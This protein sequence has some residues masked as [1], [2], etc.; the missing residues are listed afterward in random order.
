MPISAIDA[1]KYLSECGYPGLSYPDGVDETD[2]TLLNQLAQSHAHEVVH[3]R[4][5]ASRHMADAERHTIEARNIESD[6]YR[7]V[8]RIWSDD[9]HKVG[10]DFLDLNLDARHEC[11]HRVRGTVSSDATDGKSVPTDEIAAPTDGR[12]YTV[13]ITMDAHDGDVKT[14]SHTCQV[15]YDP[16]TV[17]D[18]SSGDVTNSY[19]KNLTVTRNGADA[20][21]VIKFRDTVL[22]W[23][24]EGYTLTS[25]TD[26]SL[27]FELRTM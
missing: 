25:I 22:Y 26:N 10:S 21:D 19:V 6:M 7:I 17:T 16:L 4:N 20:N 15:D 13:T 14:H 12:S 3:H 27:V 18:H 23:L 8:E 1:A 5:L 9:P 24:E 11:L 2:R